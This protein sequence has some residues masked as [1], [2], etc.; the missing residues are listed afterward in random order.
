MSKKDYILLFMLFCYLTPIM[1]VYS[2][3]NSNGSV[4]N[5]ICNDECRNIILC[6]MLLMGGGITI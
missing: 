1:L 3:Y 6:F 4:S 5:I 2:Y